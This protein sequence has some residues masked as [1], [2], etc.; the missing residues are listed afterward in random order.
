MRVVRNITPE[1]PW[2]EDCAPDT[3][4]SMQ[5]MSLQ[6]RELIKCGQEALSS[7]VSDVSDFSDDIDAGIAT[8][9]DLDGLG[10]EPKSLLSTI[11]TSQLTLLYDDFDAVNYGDVFWDS[12]AVGSMADTPMTSVDF[13]DTSMTLRRPSHAC[14]N[15]NG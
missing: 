8:P 6:L 11:P 13:Y 3:A 10:L 4:K 14:S 12:K 5:K 15:S 2:D 1:R 7:T 9:D